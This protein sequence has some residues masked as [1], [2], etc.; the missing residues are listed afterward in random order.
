MILVTRSLRRSQ[1]GAEIYMA[2]FSK[3]LASHGHPVRVLV[4]QA[5]SDERVERV[6]VEVVP[7]GIGPGFWREGKF[8]SE[9]AR[10]VAGTGAWGVATLMRGPPLERRR[11]AARARG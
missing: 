6:E 5:G 10:R 9:V 3:F 7:V 2:N 11:A 4:R 1:G 8:A